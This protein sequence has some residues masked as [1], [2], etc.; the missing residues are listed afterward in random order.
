M[1]GSFGHILSLGPL[2]VSHEPAAVMGRGPRGLCL[3]PSSGTTS[4]TT[5]EKTG[6]LN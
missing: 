1:G 6:V 2:G 4:G 5:S 3:G